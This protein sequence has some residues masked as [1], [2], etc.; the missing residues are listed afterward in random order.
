MWELNYSSSIDQLVVNECTAQ[1]VS[2]QIDTHS[3]AIRSGLSLNLLVGTRRNKGATTRW[4][5]GLR[6]SRFQRNSPKEVSAG[7]DAELPLGAED[8]RE[9]KVLLC[10][11]M[12]FESPAFELR[13]GRRRRITRANDLRLLIFIIVRR[14]A[15][16]QQKRQHQ[17]Q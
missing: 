10:L 8:K 4:T 9:S 12:K 2:K 17:Q 13:G 1:S 15:P 3:Q 14:R 5:V 6:N 7:K 11:S 16:P